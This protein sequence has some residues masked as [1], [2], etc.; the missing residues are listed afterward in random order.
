MILSNQ[1]ECLKCG[2]APYSTTR[3][4]FQYCKCGAMAVD[5]GMEYLR[6]VGDPSEIDEL[7]IKVSQEKYE[8]LAAAVEDT[9][10]NTLG[11]VCNL[12]RVLRD[13]FGINIGD[14]DE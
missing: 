10:K 12:A 1:A 11:K 8:L 6:R 7:F 3:H 9:K 5:G 2:D 13:E 4:D 14:T